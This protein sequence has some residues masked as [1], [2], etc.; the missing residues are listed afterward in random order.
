MALRRPFFQHEECL[1]M[2]SEIENIANKRHVRAAMDALA[3]STPETVGARLAQAYHP[4]AQWRGS[5]PWNELQGVDAIEQQFWRPFLHS[6]PDLERRDSLLIG[7][8]YEGRDY[9][10]AV[11]HLVARFRRDWQGIAATEQI[12]YWRYG[13]FH[14]M[15]DGLIIQS[16]VLLDVL[17]FIRQIGH[18]S[19]APS[20]GTEAFWPGPLAG[21]GIV[22]S[23]QDPAESAASLALTQA[24]QGSLRNYR[25]QRHWHDS[26]P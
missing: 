9:V 26:R 15:Q 19:L 14:Q 24:M 10:G 22:L 4:Q 2:V 25:P 12:V 1:F 16:S 8:S 20:R 18:W 6:F 17:D 11:G 13:E 5:H 23:P 3:A 7:G 21:D